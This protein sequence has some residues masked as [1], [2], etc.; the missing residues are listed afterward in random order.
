M[1]RRKQFQKYYH[2]YISTIEHVPNFL[3]LETHIIDEIN[4]FKKC[5]I[6]MF[7]SVNYHPVFYETYS[8]NKSHFVIECLAVPNQK[9]ADFPFYFKQSLDGCEGDWGTNKSIIEIKK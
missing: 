7:D 9:V 1:V 2:F 4:N 3:A 6:H 5:L 8:N